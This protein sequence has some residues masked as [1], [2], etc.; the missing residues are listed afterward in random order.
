MVH[1]IPQHRCCI[2]Q[3]GGNRRPIYR[4]VTHEIAKDNRVAVAT[5]D[6]LEQ[7]IPRKGAIRLSAG[8]LKKKFFG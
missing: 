1:K 3:R 5:S 4:K 2:Y 7:I 8:D 6:A